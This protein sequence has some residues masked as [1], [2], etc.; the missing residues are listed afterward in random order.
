LLAQ[1]VQECSSIGEGLLRFL[2][3]HRLSSYLC[4]GTLFAVLR[5]L[6]QLFR[7]RIRTKLHGAI[8]GESSISQ[9]LN[10]SRVCP[11]KYLFDLTDIPSAN[12]G[13]SSNLITHVD[14]LKVWQFCRTL[15]LSSGTH[16]V[17][18]LLLKIGFQFQSE[19]N[20]QKGIPSTPAAMAGE[21]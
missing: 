3:N 16:I 17:E 5:K 1:V 15:A 18:G 7:F 4:D 2:P 11:L 20:S 19:A 14:V 13:S 9:G 12:R 10:Q 6:F 8:D 21:N